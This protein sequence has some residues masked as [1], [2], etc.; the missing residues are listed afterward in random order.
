MK[1]GIDLRALQTGH[2]YRGIGEVAKQV[3]DRIVSYAVSDK[4]RDIEFV[5]YEYDDDDPKEQMLS[6]PKGLRFEVVKLG[7]MPENATN[8]TLKQKLEHNR[9]F[10]YGNPIERSHLCDVFLQFDYAFGVPKDSNTYLI[11]HDLIPYVFWDKYFESAWVPFKNKAARTTLRTLYANYKYKRVLK[12]GLKRAHRII[13]VSHSTKNDVIKY[14]KVA[15][16]KVKVIHLGADLKPAKT[17]KVE[18]AKL[19][20]KPYLLFVGAGD[21]RRRVDDLVAAYNN[22]K[23][24]GHDIQLALVGENFPSPEAIPNQTTRKAVMESSYIGDILTLG[25]IDDK[26]KQELYK[27]ALAYV[28]PTRY[29]GFG[30]PVLESMLLKCPIITY[31]NSSIPEIA[32]K[33]A[34]FANSWQEIVKQVKRVIAMKP[35]R[36]EEVVERAYKHASQFTWDKTAAAIYEELLSGGGK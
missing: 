28:Y 29:E 6:L 15:G 14:F 4:N 24:D 5:F 2:K 22:L 30:I 34:F 31:E 17:G 9:K 12:R 35:K 20:T 10:L 7:A 36:R 25:Y 23:A 8:R 16:K 32:G 21:A 13:A 11:K 27:N 26:T 18:K 33:D 19:P 1:I 3:T